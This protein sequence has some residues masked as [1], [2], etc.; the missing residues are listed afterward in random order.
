IELL[1]V[2]AIIAILI[3]LLLPAVQKVREAAARTVC[4][5]NLK[6]I[7][8]AVHNYESAYG[9]LPTGHG[10]Q[11][12]GPLV[13]LLSYVEQDAVKQNWS[14][15][16]WVAPGSPN[17]YSF[18]FRD[19]INQPQSGVAP[20]TSPY[21]ASGKYPVDTTIKTFICPSAPSSDPSSQWGVIR[22]RTGIT[23]GKD[24]PAAGEY[25]PAEGFTL[26]ASTTY[27]LIGG[28]HPIYGRT[29]YVPMNGWLSNTSDQYRG[30]FTYY[31]E[32]IK[33]PAISDGTSN[34]LA[35]ME[36]AG[37]WVN[38][39][40]NGAG[41]VGAAYSMGAQPANFGIC[42]KT[43]NPNCVFNP[44]EGKGMARGLP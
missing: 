3:G 16:P 40:A 7:G 4:I 39:G 13:H 28:L 31:K 43:D 22:F 44:T 19:P 14:F 20:Q 26:A 10:Q 32:K 37:G 24:F 5:N 12:E 18:Y 21:N 6:Q 1:V 29:N 23:A 36:T 33:I 27:I 30:L 42:P 9:Y 8:L 34:T 25:N 2:I 11:M 35:F 15:R 17:T 38:G 41:W